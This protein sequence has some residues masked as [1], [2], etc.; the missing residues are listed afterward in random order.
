[1]VTTT[2]RLIVWVTCV[3]KGHNPVAPHLD[4]EFE[5]CTRCSRRIHKV[6]QKWVRVTRDDF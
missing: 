4:L 2:Q 1:M 6:R 5:R 3:I